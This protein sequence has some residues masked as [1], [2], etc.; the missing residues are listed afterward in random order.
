[1]KFIILYLLALTVLLLFNYSAHS[2]ER[3][4]RELL[5]QQEN[6]SQNS[7]SKKFKA[8]CCKI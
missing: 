5:E 7:D 4:A 1:M 6:Q 2:K 3:I 8:T